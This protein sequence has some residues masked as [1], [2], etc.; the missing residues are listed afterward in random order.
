MFSYDT[1]IQENAR[2]F[3]GLDFTWGNIFGE[4][5]YFILVLLT[6]LKFLLQT[7]MI[8]VLLVLG[9]LFYS[10]SAIVFFFVSRLFISTTNAF[11]LSLIYLFGFAYTFRGLHEFFYGMHPDTLAGYLAVAMTATLIWREY[12]QS[13]NKKSTFQTLGAV[14]FLFLFLVLKEQMA[15]LA[16]IYFGIVYFFSRTPFHRNMA[17]CSL[18]VFGVGFAVIKLSQTPFNRTNEALVS[19]I[20][21]SIRENGLQILLINPNDTVFRLYP[22]W[23]V[24]ILSTVLF[25][26]MLRFSKQ[27]NPY[28]FSLFTI[29]LVQFFFSLSIPD[30]GLLEWHNFPALVMISSALLL[31]FLFIDIPERELSFSLLGVLSI[32]LFCLIAFEIPY[33]NAQLLE[34]TDRKQEIKTFAAEFTGQI[35]KEV[36]PMKVVSLPLFAVKH[37]GGYRYSFYPQGVTL[38]PVGLA[39]YIVYP[40]NRASRLA[41]RR[42]EILPKTEIPD[43]FMK[44][45]MTNNFVLFKRISFSAEDLVTR[46]FFDKYGI[47]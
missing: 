27:R 1:V 37:W 13:Q 25:V 7:R 9:P 35:M 2:G 44:I 47:K 24:I 39:D 4:H 34:N 42:D 38:S 32:S 29:G 19:N 20:I 5:A 30:F 11:F 8:Y 33:V 26:I 18:L 28:V 43:T 12:N 10:I 16:I 15:L 36:D 3:W 21:Q 17:I 31:Q 46:E 23:F 6:P 14:I 40:I 41:S 45:L 22:Y